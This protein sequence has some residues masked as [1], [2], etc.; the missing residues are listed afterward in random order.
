MLDMPLIGGNYL[1]IPHT[2][3]GHLN[4]LQKKIY[5]LKINPGLLSLARGMITLQL[6]QQSHRLGF[7]TL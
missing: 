7:G 5:A 2:K 6:C 4:H 3:N 1:S